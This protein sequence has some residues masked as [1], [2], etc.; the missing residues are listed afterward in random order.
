VEVAEWKACARSSS[1]ASSC[2]GDGVPNF[3]RLHFHTHDS[4]LCV[5]AFDLLHH[6]GRALRG[7]PLLERKARLEK[8]SQLPQD[9]HFYHGLLAD[10]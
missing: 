2:D 10:F 3:D 4:G 1:T 7:V 5:W 8:L 9:A 6:N